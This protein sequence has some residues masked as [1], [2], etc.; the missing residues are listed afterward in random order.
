MSI[1]LVRYAKYKQIFLEGGEGLGLT[2]YPADDNTHY[3]RS[4]F[5]HDIYAESGQEVDKGNY[6]IEINP[7]DDADGGY[8]ARRFWDGYYSGAKKDSMENMDLGNFEFLVGGEDNLGF[9]VGSDDLTISFSELYLDWDLYGLSSN[10]AMPSLI[11][12]PDVEVA[13][14]CSD[15]TGVQIHDESI[16]TSGFTVSRLPG[17]TGAIKVKFLIKG[18]G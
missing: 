11:P 2:L 10:I 13:R 3:V 12:Y 6:T 15:A 16:T 4:G 5:V 14:I 7:I 17:W 8:L 18:G 1:T 9:E